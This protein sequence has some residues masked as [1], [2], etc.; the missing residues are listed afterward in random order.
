MSDKLR[1]QQWQRCHLQCCNNDGVVARNAIVVA[2]LLSVRRCYYNVVVGVCYGAAVA[3]LLLE[4]AMALLLRHCW[5]CGIAGVAALLL[6]HVAVLLLQRCCGTA[7]EIFVLFFYS[8]TSGEKMRVR[9][10]K[11]SEIRNVFPDSIGWHNTSCFL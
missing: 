8:T 11:R 1:S 5:C 7:V 2:A 9:K 6:L 10:R 3:T 4:R